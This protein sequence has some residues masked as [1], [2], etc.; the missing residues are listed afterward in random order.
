M[1]SEQQ[2]TRR[3]VLASVLMG[4]GLVA[5]YGVLGIQALMFVLPKRLAVKTRL[6][7]AGQI[8]DYEEGGVRTVH[9]L[10]GTPILVKREGDEFVA[11]NSTCPHLGCKVHWLPDEGRFLC[12]CHNGIFDADGVAISGPPGDAGQVLTRVAMKVDTDARIVYL[13]VKDP[14][15]RKA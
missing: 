10:E 5:A 1:D 8:D 15:R 9:D 11:F 2:P 3:G 13:E 6:L 14:G 12:P 4:A 7:F